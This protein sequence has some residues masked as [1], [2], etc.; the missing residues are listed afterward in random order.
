MDRY[1]TYNVEIITD[2]LSK[3][4]AIL[5]YHDGQGDIDNYHLSYEK[6]ESDGMIT[7]GY[8]IAPIIYEDLCTIIGKFREA[9]I[10]V[11]KVS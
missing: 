8:R 10:Q 6:K 5:E 9:G 3:A 7:A 1:W 2:D 4:A 11:I